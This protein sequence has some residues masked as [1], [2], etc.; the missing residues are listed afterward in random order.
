MQKTDQ[1]LVYNLLKVDNRNAKPK[2]KIS[3]KLT[4]ETQNDV[5]DIVLVSLLLTLNIFYSLF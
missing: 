4:I 3:S 5:I 2:C 1:I